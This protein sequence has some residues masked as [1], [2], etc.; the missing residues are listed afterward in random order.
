MLSPQ[1]HAFPV[2]ESWKWRNSTGW[3]HIVSAQYTSACE[4]HKV[5]I[6][7]CSE[8]KAYFS[9]CPSI[10][11]SDALSVLLIT[12]GGFCLKKNALW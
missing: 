8:E 9:A 10:N 12:F 2:N 1:I 11:I 6:V 5:L 3:I 4:C 7:F